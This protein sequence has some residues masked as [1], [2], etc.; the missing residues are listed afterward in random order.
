MD[1][2]MMVDVLRRARDVNI[3]REIKLSLP[4][5]V[6]VKMGD[7]LN[8]QDVVAQAVV[9]SGLRSLDLARG[10]GVDPSEVSSFLVQDADT[11]LEQG[12]I[13]AQVDG[14][15]TRLVRMPF[16]GRLIA[17]QEGMA[18][19]A[20]E[21]LVIQKHAGLMGKVEDIIPDYGVVISV[22]GDLVQGVWGNGRV[23]C[24]ILQ[25]SRDLSERLQDGTGLDD[26]NHGQ[27]VVLPGCQ[28]R[29][30]FEQLVQK[31]IAGLILGSLSP[32]LI[33]YALNVP[34]PVLVLQGFG[35]FPVDP[36]VFELLSLSHGKQ[37]CLNAGLTDE[38]TGQ[39]PEVI[40]PNVPAPYEQPHAMPAQAEPAQE[41]SKIGFREKLSVGQKV[42]ILSGHFHGRT[43]TLVD[44]PSSPK[45]F[46]S[47]ISCLPAVVQLGEDETVTVPRQNLF[48]I[49]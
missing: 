9:P 12:D 15:I 8:P 7:V 36:D 39:R 29:E 17:C 32:D 30:L 43:G 22:R 23:N 26:I 21:N 45:T 49:A 24:G 13:L 37:C 4:G 46:E 27:V 11:F 2:K 14:T 25:A 33:R 19:I 35:D 28:D 18:Q 44:L 48:I 47:G 31:E 41:L 1:E 40:I 16:D 38:L 20:T 5:E 3:S 10:L 6:L 42:Q 34:M